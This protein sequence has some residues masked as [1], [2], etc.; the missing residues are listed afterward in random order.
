MTQFGCSHNTHM[1]LS[2]NVRDAHRYL[3]LK[4]LLMIKLLVLDSMACMTKWPLDKTFSTK[5]DKDKL[6]NYLKTIYH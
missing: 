6:E 1:L 2:G 3:N 4:L 5:T